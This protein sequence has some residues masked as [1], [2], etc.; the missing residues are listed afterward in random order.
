MS[1]M[2]SSSE[3]LARLDAAVGCQQCEGPLGDSPSDDFCSDICQHRWHAAR[4]DRLPPSDDAAQVLVGEDHVRVPLRSD[5]FGPGRL[6]P[7]PERLHEDRPVRVLCPE[8][9]CDEALPVTGFG[10][11]VGRCVRHEREHRLRTWRLPVMTRDLLGDV[12]KARHAERTAVTDAQRAAVAL[13][14]QQLR[15]RTQARDEQLRRA[16]GQ[17]F[18]RLAEVLGAAARDIGRAW[19]AA[20]TANHGRPAATPTTRQGAEPSAAVVDETHRHMS[21][22]MAEALAAQRNRGTGPPPVRLDGRRGR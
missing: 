2:D 22:V 14:M 8:D 5:L 13:R 9:G 18:P 1:L 15:E 16:L 10:A 4:A 21:P 7:T 20:L 19:T 6:Y 17:F 12:R 11:A 3:F